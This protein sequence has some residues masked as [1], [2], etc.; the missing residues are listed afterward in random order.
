MFIPDCDKQIQDSRQNQGAPGQEIEK[1][2][3]GPVFLPGRAPD[4]NEGIHG[5]EGDII[6]DE[7]EKKI[8]AHEK[9]EDAHDQQ[10]IKGKKFFDPLLQFPHGQYTGKM[11]HAGQEQQRQ[12]EPVGPVEIMNAQGLDPE[13]FF[14]ELKASLGS[15]IGDE[16]IDG[17]QKGDPGKD[18]ADPADQGLP[19]SG[20]E[21]DYQQ[22][23]QATEKDRC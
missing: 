11:D 16:Q 1:K 9:S 21:E 18:R 3:H 19:L 8:Q 7:D 23:H 20:N 12:I 10:K 5:E 22:A 2:L 17:Q 13:N 6:P 4:Q 14:Y 15:V